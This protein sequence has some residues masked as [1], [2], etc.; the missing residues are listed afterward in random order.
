MQDGCMLMA[1]GLLLHFSSVIPKTGRW[2]C[3]EA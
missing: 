2:A 3:F 1:H